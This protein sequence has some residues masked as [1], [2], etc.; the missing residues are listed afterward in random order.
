MQYAHQFGKMGVYS[1]EPCTIIYTIIII[2]CRLLWKYKCK[3]F[4]CSSKDFCRQWVTWERMFAVDFFGRNSYC[5]SL[6]NVSLQVLEN[7][8][9]NWLREVIWCFFLEWVVFGL[10]SSR[11]VIS[12]FC[13]ISGKEGLNW[14][15][16]RSTVFQYS[17]RKSI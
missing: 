15:Q 7:W 3:D 17:G 8:A 2:I 9:K 13:G 16:W 4:P 5:M 1:Q 12:H 14:G 10:F 11:L 6:N